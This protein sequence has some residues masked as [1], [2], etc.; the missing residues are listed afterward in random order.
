MHAG[1][2]KREHVFVVDS[3]EFKEIAFKLEGD[4]CENFPVVP[5]PLQG[6]LP[7]TAAGPTLSYYNPK[8]ATVYV[9]YTKTGDYFIATC[10]KTKKFT[11]LAV[12]RVQLPAPDLIGIAGQ[13]RDK[14]DHTL[15]LYSAVEMFGLNIK[16]SGIDVWMA[17]VYP[18][19]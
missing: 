10:A 13:S 2:P 9:I 3:K 15:F 1:K 4:K 18:A 12:G 6:F 7:P 11:P 17:H 5:V 19:R 16:K 8:N 14:S